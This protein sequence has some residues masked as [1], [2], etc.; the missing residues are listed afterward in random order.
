MDGVTDIRAGPLKIFAFLRARL[1]VF[2]GL[3]G[4]D[5]SRSVCTPGRESSAPKSVSG[6]HKFFEIMHKL[7]VSV[8]D[9]YRAL[10][11]S[12]F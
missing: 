9:P 1:I 8:M 4:S 2:S 10:G 11:Q 12:V 5:P 3:A 6:R 7:S